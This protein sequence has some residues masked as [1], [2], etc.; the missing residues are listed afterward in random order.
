[1]CRLILAKGRF[2]SDEIV[3]AAVMMS[4]GETADH[5]G[6]IRQHPNGWGA[7]WRSPDGDRPLLAHRDVRPIDESWRGAPVTSARTDLLVVHVRH[8]TLAA[9]QGLPC[10]HPLERPGPRGP[11]F[12][13]HNGFLPT[14]YQCL[15]R[16]RSEFDSAEY[17]EYLVPEAVD[18]LDVERSASRLRLIPPGGSS[19]NAILINQAWAHVVHWTFEE[20]PYP[21]YFTMH[22]LVEDDR[23]IISSEIIPALGPREQWIPLEQRTIVSIPIH[24]ADSI[25][26]RS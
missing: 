23:T 14:V 21:R 9:N 22:K 12:L 8:A 6:P 5:E 25:K 3:A 19:A 20:S 4:R 2:A 10:T 15:G 11:W 13:L 16:E 24:P 26:G 7:V 18:V 1:M 17:F